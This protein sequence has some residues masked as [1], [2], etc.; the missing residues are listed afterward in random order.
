V[1]DP[2]GKDVKLVNLSDGAAIRRKRKSR[3][4]GALGPGKAHELVTVMGPRCD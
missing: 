3:A 1:H 2:Q 4:W